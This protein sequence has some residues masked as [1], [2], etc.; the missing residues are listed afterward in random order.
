MTPIRIC[1]EDERAAVVS[2]INSA[3]EAYR[4]I[5]PADRWHEPYMSA[6]ELD[7][8]IASGVTFWGYDESN[9]TLAASARCR[10]HPACKPMTPRDVPAKVNGSAQYAIDVQLPG[11]VYASS[12]HSPVHNALP[13]V[14]DPG[15]QDA[16]Y[17][18]P[19]RWND[20]D[21]RAMKGVIDIV[22]LPNGLA[23]VADHFED[24]IAARDALKVTWAKARADGFDSDRA[25]A[26]YA[27]P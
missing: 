16:S 27:C 3:A 13:K 5:I 7:R 20:A 9:G 26:D 10:S 22:A 21:V 15:F 14:W 1:R 24:A 11:M 6:G 12:L 8:E 2:I 25:L 23:V 19:E 18:R 4:G 17:A